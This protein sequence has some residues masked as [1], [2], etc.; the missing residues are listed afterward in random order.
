PSR[1]KANENST[2]FP[3]GH[4]DAD[5]EDLEQNFRASFHSQTMAQ[6]TELRIDSL[7]ITSKC[8]SRT[9]S[10]NRR[11]NPWHQRQRSS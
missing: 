4:L 9:T 1:Q 10:R 5:P 11:A 7:A 6:L 3:A 2:I 8:P